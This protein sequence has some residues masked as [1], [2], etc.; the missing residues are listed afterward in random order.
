DPVWVTRVA[1]ASW[2]L[3]SRV[4]WV[5]FSQ[6]TRPGRP[7]WGMWEAGSGS[8]YRYAMESAL[9]QLDGNS[10]V[11]VCLTYQPET[12]RLILSPW[13]FLPGFRD[14]PEL[15][16]S[17]SYYYGGDHLCVLGSRSACVLVGVF[18][19]GLFCYR[20]ASHGQELIPLWTGGPGLAA[21][22]CEVCF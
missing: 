18:Q 19:E 13:Q 2:G 1:R 20:D 16:G 21:P 3:A 4:H 9:R 14:I 12:D 17:P 15:G 22:A 10:Q 11:G 5:G 6:D 7:G 8:R